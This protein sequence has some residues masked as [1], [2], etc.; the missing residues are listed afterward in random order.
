MLGFAEA[1][2]NI[3]EEKK[4][5]KRNPVLRELKTIRK[6]LR[7]VD[8]RIGVMVLAVATDT[9]TNELF[10]AS[11][12]VG[13]DE[14]FVGEVSTTGVAKLICRKLGMKELRYENSANVSRAVYSPNV[15]FF[16]SNNDSRA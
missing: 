1:I 12:Y 11:F 2:N 16:F 10:C 4:P 8:E 3:I 5:H 7:G 6:K 14:R 9:A 13:H 15:T